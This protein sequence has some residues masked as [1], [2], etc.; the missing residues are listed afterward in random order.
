MFLT[1]LEN[2][3]TAMVDSTRGHKWRVKPNIQSLATLFD[4]WPGTPYKISS[5]KLVKIIHL[6]NVVISYVFL[7]VVSLK[8]LLPYASRGHFNLF[9]IDKQASSVSIL[10]PLSVFP[11]LE[12]KMVRSHNLQLKLQRIAIYLSDALALAQPGWDADI[13][14]WPRTSPVGIPE[15]PD[16]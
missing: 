6:S 4:S 16:R 9:S 12:S 3:Q 8:V 15:N 14:S 13:F 7:M 5:C 2:A 1:T 10:D 11:S